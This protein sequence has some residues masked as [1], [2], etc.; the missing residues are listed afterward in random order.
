MELTIDNLD[1]MTPEQER[2]FLKKF[3]AE[4]AY[5]DGSEAHSHLAAGRPIYY[6]KPD[7]PR[8]RV[9]KEYPDGR[10]QLVYFV[11][12]IEVFDADLPSV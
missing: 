11:D 4:L 5:D 2:T 8:D 7:T 1:R 3:D 10:R 9:I 12:G 6:A